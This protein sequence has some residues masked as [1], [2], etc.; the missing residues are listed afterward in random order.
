MG[1]D[2]QKT[3]KP[4]NETGTDFA[5]DVAKGLSEPFKTIPSLYFYDNHGSELFTEITRL[6]EYYLT[7][8]EY[9]ILNMQAEA[10]TQKIINLSGDKTRF[11]LIELGVGDSEKPFKVIKALEKQ[12]IDF[13]YTAIDISMSALHQFQSKFIA[14][15]ANVKND[16]V[17]AEY[18]TGLKQ[19]TE[20]TYDEI[21]I[22][23]FLGSNLGNFEKK[24]SLQF[25]RLLK[26]YGKKSSFL[27]IGLDLKKDPVTLMAAYSDQQ[28][29]TARFNLNLLRRIN[30][31]L[32]ADFNLEKFIHHAVF[33][34]VKGAME[35][36]LLSTEQQT[37]HIK[38][39]NM[40]VEFDTFEPIHTEYSFKY[41]EKMI[42]KMAY[43][44]GYS[45]I[46]NYKD[47]R[48]FFTDS[49]WYAR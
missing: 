20:R 19:A 39:C 49:L 16:I 36:Y 42:D 12:K 45:V 33:N 6:P 10:I 27:L 46:K 31:E 7:N 30:R 23:L 29:V 3:Y 38:K 34:P 17:H 40:K 41:T 18:I 35:S 37:V 47:N 2:W 11:H 32:D 9:E 1:L 4:M 14:S 8:S 21:N 44:A 43:E 22:I 24:D 13:R 15:F 48:G 5:K 25:L 26:R 28:Q